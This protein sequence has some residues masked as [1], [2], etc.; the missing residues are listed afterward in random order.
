[1]VPR[2]IRS[3]SP[4]H[5]N[6]TLTKVKTVPAS[7]TNSLYQPIQHFHKH[8]SEPT[9][10]L[11]FRESI[12]N[13]C[14]NYRKNR[15]TPYKTVYGSSHTKTHTALKQTFWSDQ[16]HVCPIIELSWILIIGLF[17]LSDT[18][19][20]LSSLLFSDR[21]LPIMKLEF[22]LIA[23]LAFLQLAQA[24]APACGSFTMIWQPNEA[25]DVVTEGLSCY[26]KN[27]CNWIEGTNEENSCEI[28][29]NCGNASKSQPV[30]FNNGCIVVGRNQKIVSTCIVKYGL[31]RWSCM[32]K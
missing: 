2:V 22:V 9:L 18:H 3:S 32:Q 11:L 1:M 4:R 13:A 19:S 14:N 10:I 12:R 7:F 20:P 21:T 5:C 15:H 16:T 31:L 30:V 8:I 23:C 24:D 26:T 6:L 25:R 27:K 28:R 17:T 29:Y